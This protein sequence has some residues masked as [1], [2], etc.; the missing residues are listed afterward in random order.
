MSGWIPIHGHSFKIR[1]HFCITARN[2]PWGYKKNK[3]WVR[4]SDSGTHNK[5]DVNSLIRRVENFF[6]EM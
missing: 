2:I 3:I 5:E 6:V 1:P 4:T